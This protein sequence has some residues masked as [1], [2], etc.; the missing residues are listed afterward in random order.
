[1]DNY[2][3][4]K[5]DYERILQSIKEIKQYQDELIAENKRLN[6]VI[7]GTKAKLS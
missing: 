7:N 5:Q 3:K 2:D 4:I 1:M 6:E